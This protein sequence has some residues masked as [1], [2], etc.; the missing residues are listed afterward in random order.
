MDFENFVSH[1]IKTESV[2]DAKERPVN[3]KMFR[4][5]IKLTVKSAQLADML[6]KG[7]FYNKSYDIDAV[8]LVLE[9]INALS[10]TLWGQFYQ[11]YGDEQGKSEGNPF[12]GQDVIPFNTRVLHGIL[13]YFTES[14]EMLEFLD[15]ALDDPEMMPDYVNLREEIGDIDWYKA[16]LFDAMSFLNPNLEFHEGKIREIIINKL[17]ARYGDKFDEQAAENRNLTA[18]RQILEEKQKS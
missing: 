5:I 10:S 6:K 2:I 12:K 4:N 7:F 16:I 14:G 17:K 13:G 15:R 3:L 8:R 9:E 1:A 18:E 11:V